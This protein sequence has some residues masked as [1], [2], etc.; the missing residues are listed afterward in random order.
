MLNPWVIFGNAEL[1]SATVALL[2]RANE[3]SYITPSN[4]GALDYLIKGMKFIDIW[5]DF[6][7]FYL[8]SSDLG[9]N[10]Q[11]RLIDI[12]TP[13]RL[14][15]ISG[16]ITFSNA[17]VIGNGTNAWINT[18]YN[19][20]NHAIHFTQ[21]NASIGAIMYE[22]NAVTLNNSTIGG[23][24]AT[25]QT[26]ISLFGYNT[27]ENRLN[28]S[29]V[30]ANNLDLSGVGL[31][32]INR[33]SPSQINIINRDVVDTALGDSV[34]VSAFSVA[35]LRRSANYGNGTISCYFAGN[36]ISYEKAQQFRNLYNNYLQMLGL[37]QIA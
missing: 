1:D 9:S 19:P 10:Y 11:F 32:L 17:G 33:S 36:P 21:N 13:T 26:N 14:A 12:K 20:A 29:T 5:N 31:K 34:S 3:L 22:N 35:L 2:A 4:I 28:Q 37:N 8:F 23:L 7:F 25:G 16:G 27:N 24:G 30:S 15:N 18:M 6:D